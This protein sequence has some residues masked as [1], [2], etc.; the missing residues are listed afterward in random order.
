MAEILEIDGFEGVEGVEGFDNDDGAKVIVNGR[1]WATVPERWRR[2]ESHDMTVP[3]WTDE[4]EQARIAA[5]RETVRREYGAEAGV[6]M[7]EGLHYLGPEAHPVMIQLDPGRDH[8]RTVY[9]G[10]WH[11]IVTPEDDAP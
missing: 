6:A 1:V 8:A 11:A 4:D 10:D 7:A 2:A 3:D 9:A 5:V